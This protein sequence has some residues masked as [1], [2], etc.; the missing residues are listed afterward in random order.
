MTR[1]LCVILA[2]GLSAS[3]GT[4]LAQDTASDF[5]W[6]TTASTAT[7]FLEPGSSEV[8]K[9]TVGEK[10][11]VVYRQGERI[12]VRFKGST[13]GWIDASS[14]SASDPSDAVPTP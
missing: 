4:A 13:F 3:V 9:T 2:L 7:R 11:Q 6:V 14:V 12:R 8:E 10:L 1:F 5:V